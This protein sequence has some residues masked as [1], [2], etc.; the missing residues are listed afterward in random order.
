M[1][2][3][4]LRNRLNLKP[5]TLERRLNAVLNFSQILVRPGLTRI[6]SGA[7]LT[8]RSGDPG[9]RPEPSGALRHQSRVALRSPGMTC[10]MVFRKADQLSAGLRPQAVAEAPAV[11]QA[12][13]AIFEAAITAWVRL[14]TSSLVRM[15]ETWA[16]TVAS[17]TPSS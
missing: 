4:A 3:G 16:F 7:F 15:A 8:Q 2:S 14:S 13:P 1:P 11:A 10:P 6:K 9:S 5:V 17:E 12:V